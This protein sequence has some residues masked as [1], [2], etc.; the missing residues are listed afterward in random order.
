MSVWLFEREL[1]GVKR[2]LLILWLIASALLLLL[3]VALGY[4][5]LMMGAVHW[6]WWLSAGLG[7]GFLAIAVGCFWMCRRAYGLLDAGK[8]R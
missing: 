1:A 7:A 4:M 3:A 8:G 5:S 6:D 2:L